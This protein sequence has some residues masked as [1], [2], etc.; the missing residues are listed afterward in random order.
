MRIRSKITL[1]VTALMTA[2][3]GLIA[4]DLALVEA[5]R[6]R[7]ESADRTHTMMEGVMRIGRESLNASDELMLLSYL[8]LLMQ[9]HPEIELAVVSREGH[10]SVLGAIH[11]DL[12]YR[13]ITLTESA[14]ASFHEAPKPAVG[15]AAAPSGVLPVAEGTLPP[16]SF[17][18]QL[19]FSKAAL[20]RQIEALQTA[21]WT[22][23]AAIAAFGLLLG[24]AGSLWVGRLLAGPV[25]ELAAAAERLGQGKLDTHVEVRG[26]DE[27]AH[28]STRF[29]E[30][31]AKIQEVVQFKEDLMSTLSHEMRTPLGGLK[32]FLQYLQ[33]SPAAQNP[34][35]RDEAYSTMLEAV[36]QM[37]LSLGNALQL[38][39][40]GARPAIQKEPVAFHEVVGEVLRL[41]T[42]AAQTNG[43]TLIGPPSAR[44]AVV[45]GDR[46]LLR[47]I[48]I[49]L[50]SNALLYTPSGGEVRVRLD[51]SGDTIS[52]AV[53]DTGPG[54]APADRQR[55]F[56]KFYRGAGA[57]GRPQRIP[58]SG[59][60]LAIAKQAVDLHKGRIWVDSEIG[61][62]S[63]F[64]ITLP[65]GASVTQ[66]AH[67]A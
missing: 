61:M 42:P 58:G 57:D 11:G 8:K 28:L 35:E 40:A 29:N 39:R 55:I 16:D 56:E 7:V 34:K 1:L 2:L 31:A 32:G 26:S 54:V 47:R 51:D 45:L 5:T 43:V 59:L 10:T 20:Q 21:L 41:F 9:E 17:T 13:T 44:P 36:S 14:S 33:D 52:L 19:G 63:T 24:L 38:F 46:E 4:I 49:N 22:K 6:L 53:A 25:A 62:G 30:M 27:L 15:V 65:K 48:V 37:E 64:Q 66:E 60:G 23:I 12:F 18:I 50:V 3:V 67:A